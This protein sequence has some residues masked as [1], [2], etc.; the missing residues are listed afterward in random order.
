MTSTFRKSILILALFA[1]V[2]PSAFASDCDA[3]YES[4]AVDEASTELALDCYV[5][6][7]GTLPD[8]DRA[9]KS[10]A[11]NRASYLK[12][13]LGEYFQSGTEQTKLL[14]QGMEWGEQ[15]V[16]LFGAK[17]S[18]NDYKK[19]STEELKLLAEALYAYGLN[20]SRYIDIK[21]MPE[22]LIHMGDIKRSMQ[23]I[24]RIKQESIAYYGAHRTLGIFNTVVPGIA[25]GDLSAAKDYLLQAITATADAQ[26]LSQYPANNVA[27]A[28]WLFKS[29]LRSEACAQLKLVTE[30]SD[31][32]VR[33]LKNGLYLE[34]LSDL[35]KAKAHWTQ[36]QCS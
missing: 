6:Q 20:S 26:G 24:I 36:Y 18:L 22:A 12:F 27:Y 25:G 15:S 8:S 7:L 2:L 28:E 17:Y 32:Q 34:T 19:L 21:G 23:T 13:Y 33:G 30:L 5:S 31:D 14:K 9:L 29:N 35:K 4:R 10:H 1:S 16:L 11:Y 3:L